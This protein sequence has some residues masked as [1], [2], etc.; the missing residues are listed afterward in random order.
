MINFSFQLLKTVEIRQ[1]NWFSNMKKIASK[2]YEIRFD[3]RKSLKF[4]KITLRLKSVMKSAWIMWNDGITCTYTKS[5]IKYNSSRNSVWMN[6]LNFEFNEVQHH[7]ISLHLHCMYVFVSESIVC[8]SGIAT[9]FPR[10]FNVSLDLFKSCVFSC[11]NI[12]AF[13]FSLQTPCR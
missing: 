9:N 3:D 7:K 5:L 11:T 8:L 4:Y 6:L 13:H 10:C 2:S 12:V 1:R